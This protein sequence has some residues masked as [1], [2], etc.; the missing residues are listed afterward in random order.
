MRRFWDIFSYTEMGGGQYRAIPW[1][2]S[3]DSG[4]RP[5]PPSRLHYT[6]IRVEEHNHLFT[7]HQ[8]IKEKKI[9]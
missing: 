3:E 1:H 4:L 2:D 6:E 8:C 9:L 5:P 7:K